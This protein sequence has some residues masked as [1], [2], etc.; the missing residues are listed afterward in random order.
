LFFSKG[1]E[2][3]LTPDKIVFDFGEIREGMNPCVRFSLTNTG[4]EEIKLQ[5]IRTFAA[6]VQSRPFEKKILTPGQTFE[7]DLVFESL[8]YGGAGIN[9]PIEIH[10]D[11]PK[12][13]PLKLWVK[14]TVLP[15]ESHQAS[16][17]EM[18]YNFFVLV[19]IRP[20][21]DYLKEHILG[22]LNVPVER[23][24]A[25]ISLVSQSLSKE[26]IIYVIGEGGMESD[27]I[28]KSLRKKGYPQFI[29]IVGGIKE[30]KQ[31]NGSKFLVSELIK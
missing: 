7:L 31:R 10:Y 22:A 27:K 20:A 11:D 3:E 23:I 17:D 18:T 28:V 24:N 16:L 9:K 5:E 29:S 8:G 6:C 2:K 21:K 26:L 13:S 14:G 4:T 19:D 30:W 25:W 1:N 12:K 15:L